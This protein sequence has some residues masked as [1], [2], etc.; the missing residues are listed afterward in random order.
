MSEKLH[1]IDGHELW[2]D[3]TLRIHIFL[4]ECTRDFKFSV[5]IYHNLFD[6]FVY[7]MTPN[8]IDRNFKVIDIGYSSNPFSSDVE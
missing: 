1:N 7:L 5:M 3:T 2:H 4:M 8:D 6:S